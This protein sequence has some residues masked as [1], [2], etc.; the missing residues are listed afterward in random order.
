M[1]RSA[2]IRGVNTVENQKSD[3]I[4]GATTPA[5]VHTEEQAIAALLGL[6]EVQETTDQ[7]EGQPEP[8]PEG[9]DEPE[10]GGEE[11]E[12]EGEDEPE[13]GDDGEPEGLTAQSILKQFE[14]LDPE[15]IEAIGKELGSKAITRFG[16]LTARAKAAEEELARIKS[17]AP[18]PIATEPVT[19][20]FLEGVD[21]PEKLAAKVAELKK[22]GKETT[23][24]LL[25][26]EDFG[27]NDEIQIGEKTITKKQLRA[28]DLE[29]R[30]ALEEAVPY[31]QA[32]FARMEMIEAEQAKAEAQ[33]KAQVTELADAESEVAK[34]YK[35]LTESDLFQRIY[36]AFP[37]AKP[38][39]TILAAHGPKS[40]LA[41]KAKAPAPVTTGTTPKAK[42]PGNPASVAGAPARTEP[43]A[44]DQERLLERAERGSRADAEAYLASRL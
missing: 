10:P 2:I 39:L 27:S 17:Q 26:H 44:K 11:P 16:K 24:V 43:K 42:P 4:T 40:F 29:V 33:I 6:D 5:E 14:G 30:E 28:L 38:V 25:D 41:K 18:Q 20:R 32:E 34:T 19:S 13:G 15:E 35:G 7:P 8:E 22:L 1:N 12:G 37:E 9:D 36:K 31:K 23:R 3:A 21:S